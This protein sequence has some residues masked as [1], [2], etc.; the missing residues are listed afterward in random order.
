[1]PVLDGRGRVVGIAAAKIVGTQTAF[2]IPPEEVNDLLKG[3]GTSL[4]V[5]AAEGSTGGVDIFVDAGVAD[6]FGLIRTIDA[7]W[8]RKSAL[9]TASKPGE[10]GIWAE[11][12]ADMAIVA[13]KLAADRQMA[14]GQFNFKKDVGDPDPL[15]IT[16]QLR[17]QRSTEE[18]WS[19][20]FEIELTFSPKPVARVVDEDPLTRPPGPGPGPGP[21]PPDRPSTELVPM[22]VPDAFSEPRMVKVGG[23][24]QDFFASPDGEWLF[25]LDVFSC[26][27]LK[28]HAETMELTAAY[29]AG[30]HATALASS[31]SGDRL[32][33]VS[34]VSPRAPSEPPKWRGRL[35]V[36]DPRELKPLSE[37]VFDGDPWDL[38]VSPEGMLVVAQQPPMAGVLFVNPE[39]G[40]V[41]PVAGVSESGADN[42]RIHPDGARIYATNGQGGSH[43]VCFSSAAP[44]RAGFATVNSSTYNV[45]AFEITPDG[46]FSLASNG[47][48]LRHNETAPAGRDLAPW[49][50][51][52][53]SVTGTIDP[54]TSVAFAPG[55]ETFFSAHSSGI[56]KARSL[57]DF[58]LVKSVAVRRICYRLLL[59]AKRKILFAAAAELPKEGTA[60]APPSMQAQDLYAWPL[61][62]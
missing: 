29:D 24:I 42:L 31:P 21:K 40:A 46:R 56:V 59:D 36:L 10:G 51:E 23:S 2:A 41:S 1:G 15:R 54:W 6:A 18:R 57:K 17:W 48:C 12:S 8:I 25:A 34:R 33:V 30:A 5:R 61:E 38:A 50:L 14:S 16:L 3:R 53:A 26:R 27:V 19:R 39:T 47:A 44:A 28:I 7:R 4:S 49:A 32:Y 45:F 43:W 9:A 13:L 62:K 37:V 20:P 52:G 60:P 55:I 22:L 35:V 11:A 58:S